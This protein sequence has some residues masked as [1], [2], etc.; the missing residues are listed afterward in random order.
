MVPV[1]VISL[2]IKRFIYRTLD[3]H[4][5]TGGKGPG[6]MPQ[7]YISH[8]SLVIRILNQKEVVNKMWRKR[9]KGRLSTMY[10]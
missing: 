2:L 6:V 10:Y 1:S 9:R 3:T 8:F 5:A 4:A 7:F